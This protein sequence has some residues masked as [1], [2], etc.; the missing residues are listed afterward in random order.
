MKNREN[1]KGNQ[2]TEDRAVSVQEVF[3]RK[4]MPTKKKRQANVGVVKSPLFTLR[5]AL[6]ESSN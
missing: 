6:R 5:T 1:C 2:G 3:Y 4:S